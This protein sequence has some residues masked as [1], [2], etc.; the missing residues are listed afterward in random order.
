[1]EQHYVALD[2][3]SSNGKIVSA[4]LDKEKKLIMREVGRFPTPRIW[5][6]VH[7]RTDIY[8]VYKEVCNALSR[9]SINGMKIKSFGADSWSSDFGLITPEGE[10]L[11][12]PIFYRDKWTDGI[13]EEVEKFINYQELYTLTTQRRMRDATLCQLLALKKESPELL[14]NGNK[15]MCLGDI[16][17]YFFSGKVCSEISVA[18]Y[19]QLFSMKNMCWENQLFDL[20]GIPKGI[21]PRIVHA[22]EYLGKISAEQARVLGVNCFEVIAPPVHDTAAAGVAVPAKKEENWAYL[23]T[24][25]WYLVS[26]E[27]DKPADLFLSYRYN[28]SNTGLAFGNTLLKRNVCAMWLIQECRRSWLKSRPDCDYQMITALASHAK[29]FAG[30]IVVF[31]IQMIW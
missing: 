19:S 18:S 5:I 17:M 7:V 20:F 23:A 16:L 2:M 6:N 4:Y 1:M 25:S 12:L 11:G 8:G 10:L 9:L 27:I 3:G 28:L 13:P 30:M 24:G 15:L 22:G 21:Q 26:M 14:N 31:I 29:P